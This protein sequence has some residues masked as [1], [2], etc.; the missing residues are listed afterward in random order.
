[1]FNGVLITPL[2]RVDAQPAITCSKLSIKHK[3]KVC[4]RFKVNNKDTRT[5]PFLIFIQTILIRFNSRGLSSPLWISI[6]QPLLHI[7]SRS[8]GRLSVLQENQSKGIV[9]SRAKKGVS[10]YSEKEFVFIFFLDILNS[11]MYFC[12]FIFDKERGHLAEIH[13]SYQRRYWFIH[14]MIKISDWW[15]NVANDTNK[16]I[17]S[18]YV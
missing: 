2:R 18:K 6:I 14:W 1:M 8:I 3:N 5:T 11:K 12:V 13:V 9:C 4:N 15:K 7:D 10:K 16:T 17:S